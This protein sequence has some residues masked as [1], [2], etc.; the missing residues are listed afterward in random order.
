MKVKLN[1]AVARKDSYFVFIGNDSTQT[2][3]H[4]ELGLGK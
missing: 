2:T 4:K 1:R 3:K